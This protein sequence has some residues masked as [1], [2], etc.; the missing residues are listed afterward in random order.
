MKQ[1]QNKTKAKRRQQGQAPRIVQTAER[2][3]AVTRRHLWRTRVQS[4]GLQPP[5]DQVQVHDPLTETRFANTAISFNLRDFLPQSSE[6]LTTV[7]QFKFDKIDVYCQISNLPFDNFFRR[8]NVWYKADFDDNNVVEWEDLQS[9]DN[10]SMKTLIPT[11][12]SVMV[13]LMTI[14]PNADF[15]N[16]PLGNS[17][18]N[19]ILNGNTWCDTNAVNQ[20][21][22]GLKV[23]IETNFGVSETKVPKVTFPSFAHISF[24]GKVELAFLYPHTLTSRLLFATLGFLRVNCK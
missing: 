2:S 24:R 14:K 9:R 23:H 16:D 7:D 1:K 12:G 4:L 6:F 19:M 8:F 21:F 22:V 18:S 10:V 5:T 17:P 15:R 20:N 11:N 13:K 3:L